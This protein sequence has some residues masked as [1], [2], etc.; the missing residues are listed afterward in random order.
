MECDIFFSANLKRKH[1]LILALGLEDT[2]NW[3]LNLGEAV[4][5]ECLL[6]LTYF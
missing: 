2:T 5:S 3:R 1:K 4:K 6:N